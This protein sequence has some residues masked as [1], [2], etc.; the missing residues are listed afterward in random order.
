M[1]LKVTLPRSVFRQPALRGEIKITEDQARDTIIAEVQHNAAEVLKERMNLDL[2]L[3]V[4][5]EGQEKL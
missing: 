1:Q 4:I 2:N 5:G 3:K